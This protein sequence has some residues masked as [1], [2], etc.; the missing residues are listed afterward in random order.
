MTHDAL[1][2]FGTLAAGGDDRGRGVA[3]VVEA[4]AAPPVGLRSGRDAGA[5][6]ERVEVTPHEVRR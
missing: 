4:E 6:A 3:H 1:D 5:R 2:D